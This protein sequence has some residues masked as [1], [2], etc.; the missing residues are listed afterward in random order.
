MKK[1]QL[2]ILLT[3]GLFLNSCLEI[4]EDLKINSDG[5]GVFKV[6][7]NL[8]QS[9]SQI[10]KLLSQD[11]IQGQPVPKK[12]TIA[13][14]LETLKAELESQNGISNVVQEIDLQN[15]IVKLSFSFD[16]VES[17]NIAVNN[18][19]KK[20]DPNAPLNPVIYSFENKNFS[21]TFNSE[22]LSEAYKN[23]EKVSAFLADFDQAKLTSI[24]KFESEIISNNH[25]SSKLSSSKKS[26]IEFTYINQLLSNNQLHK[27]NISIQ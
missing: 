14:K 25:S 26:C 17:L 11:S 18:I 2:L 23:K 6:I 3:L 4:V 20:Q 24:F 5:T 1:I 27:H 7:V 10:D 8:S 16:K 22:L 21:R 12:E 13:Q 9:R 19:I 15:Y